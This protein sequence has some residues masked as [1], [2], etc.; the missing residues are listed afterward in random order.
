M[1]TRLRREVAPAPRQKPHSLMR[2]RVPR[3][4]LGLAATPPRSR[5]SC[6]FPT[7]VRGPSRPQQGPP[8]RHWEAGSRR[9]N[10]RCSCTKYRRCSPRLARNWDFGPQWWP[11]CMGSKT[12][13][14]VDSK[15]KCYR[16]D[17][18]PAA[19][20]ARAV[21]AVVAIVAAVLFA[22]GAADGAD[23]AAAA[24]AA[25]CCCFPQSGFHSL[26]R[27]PRPLPRGQLVANFRKPG[28]WLQI[29]QGN[30]HQWQAA[31]FCS[32][33]THFSR[34]ELRKTYL[35]LSA[36]RLHPN[37]PRPISTLA[38]WGSPVA[39]GARWR[40]LAQTLVHC[41]FFALP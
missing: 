15:S 20:A 19:G 30:D 12:N 5:G 26:A 40:H 2:R 37:L 34:P 24:A 23:A 22:D 4:G 13:S 29:P 17:C 14:R 18:L 38:L 6:C 31:H 39:W 41:A 33:G 1:R 8:A 25:A 28:I 11:A 21:V 27:W 35:R 32:G 3:R 9:D 7:K 16:S 10:G 36:P